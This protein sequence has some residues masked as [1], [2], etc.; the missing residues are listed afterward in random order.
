MKAKVIYGEHRGK[1]GTVT[2]MLWAANLAIIELKS[3][4]EIA[5]KPTDILVIEE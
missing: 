1:T 2:N 5:V 3:G 4:Q